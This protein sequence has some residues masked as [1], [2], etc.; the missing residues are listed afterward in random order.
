MVCP[1]VAAEGSDLASMRDYI[2]LI[3]IN[4]EKKPFPML[5][6]SYDFEEGVCRFTGV[7]VWATFAF[8]FY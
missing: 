2:S 1:G 4:K 6:L 5:V 7:F 8:I 3:K